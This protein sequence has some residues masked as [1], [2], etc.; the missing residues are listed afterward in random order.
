MEGAH[1]NVGMGHKFLR[2]IERTQLLL[3]VVDI[4]GFQLS[5]KHP[6]RSA[7]DTLHLLVDEL[8]EYQSELSK[9]PAILAI[10][11]MDREGASEKLEQLM[12]QI[13]SSW[14]KFKFGGILPISA[15]QRT[16]IDELKAMIAKS[17]LTQTT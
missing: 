15:L 14:S 7:W 9:R 2:H 3:F 4:E 13:T 5:S 12:K 11:K 17:L 10:N 6:E 1:A 8:E 16:G